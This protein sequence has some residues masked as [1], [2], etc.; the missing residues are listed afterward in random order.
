MALTM[1][2]RQRNGDRLIVHVGRHKTGSTSLQ[3]IF[4]DQP[5]GRV[6]ILYPKTARRGHQHAAL[7]ASMLGSAPDCAGADRLLEGLAQEIG[8]MGPR[9]TL[10]SSEVFCELAK[11]EPGRCSLLLAQLAERWR[12]ELLQVVRPLPAYFLSALKHQLRAGTFVTRSPLSWYRHCQEK[13]ATLD[14]F[15]THAGYP[16]MT[17]PYD[18]VDA[19]RPVVAHLAECAGLQAGA[20]HRL[21]T[22]IPRTRENSSLC[23]AAT[24]AA[25]FVYLLAA[26]ACWLLE[27]ID[28]QLGEPAQSAPILSFDQFRSRLQAESRLCEQ[29]EHCGLDDRLLLEFCSAH[30]ERSMA[31]GDWQCLLAS[32]FYASFPPLFVQWLPSLGLDI[33]HVQ[34]EF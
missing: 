31:S 22:R 25:Y 16:L 12:L 10:L 15:W 19:C 4:A 18:A 20:A 14:A 2:W 6:G 29:L 21:L 23:S 11:R 27:P 26:R 7:P 8:A 34:P 17:I 9:L 33:R 24:Y 32:Q 13:T 5:L 1:P 28:D 30:Q 3:Q